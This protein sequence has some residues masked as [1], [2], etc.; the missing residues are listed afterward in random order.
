MHQVLGQVKVDMVVMIVLSDS[1]LLLNSFFSGDDI[2]LGQLVVV[3]LGK[4]GI[5][6]NTINFQSDFYA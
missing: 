3:L 6:V 2:Q 1:I 4:H 5:R